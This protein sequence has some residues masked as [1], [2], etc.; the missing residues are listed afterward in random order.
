MDENKKTDLSLNRDKSVFIGMYGADR[1]TR[2]PD[3]I[4]TMDALYHLSYI[5]IQ[6][7]NYY[8]DSD[9]I[10]QCFQRKRKKRPPYVVSASS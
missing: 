3:L 10:H 9:S 1:G 6:C 5:G 2:T 7:N 8:N 4:L